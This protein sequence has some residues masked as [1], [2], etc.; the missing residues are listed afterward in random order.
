MFSADRPGC[1]LLHLIEV[2][3]VNRVW[4]AFTQRLIPSSSFISA[5]SLCCWRSSQQN[6]LAQYHLSTLDVKLYWSAWL[7]MLAKRCINW[8]CCVKIWI[9][10]FVSVIQTVHTFWSPD[11]ETVLCLFRTCLKVS[12]SFLLFFLSFFF[13]NSS[14]SRSY[15][16]T[17]ARFL[18][19]LKESQ[20]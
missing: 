13:F 17:S 8:V 11:C 2:C 19:C 14:A 12:P 16:S 4:R 6:A 5:Y 20:R 9:L 1:V 3:G 10:T 7:A 18:R 15:F